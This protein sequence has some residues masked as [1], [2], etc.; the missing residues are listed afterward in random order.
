MRSEQLLAAK[1]AAQQHLDTHQ[2]TLYDLDEL[3]EIMSEMLERQQA[4]EVCLVIFPCCFV[5]PMIF[6]DRER[7]TFDITSPSSYHHR[8]PTSSLHLVSILL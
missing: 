5:Y 3:G 4:V 1:Q 8:R 2:R 7:G 6:A